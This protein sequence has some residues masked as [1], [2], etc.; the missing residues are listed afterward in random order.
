[1]DINRALKVM[2]LKAGCS[3]EEVK[4][5]FRKLAKENHPDIKGESYNKIFIDINE[6]YSVLM[7]EGTSNRIKLTHSTIF[8]IVRG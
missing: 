4:K 2:N 1:M 7:K 3:K 6:A 8:D 5:Q